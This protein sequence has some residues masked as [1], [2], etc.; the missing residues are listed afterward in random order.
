MGHMLVSD[1]RLFEYHVAGAKAAG[2]IP[3]DSEMS[4]ETVRRFIHDDQ[5]TVIVST[6]ENLVQEFGCFETAL[7]CLGNRYWTLVTAAAAALDF[8]TCDHPVT[9]RFTDPYRRGPCGYGLPETEVFFPLNTRQ[10]L[11]GVFEDP[12]PL[13][14]EVDTAQ[15]AAFN[16]R[17]INH[18]YRQVY[19]KTTNVAL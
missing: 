9:V 12:L 15:I 19:T 14:I 18:T 2:F 1:K 6:S 13:R 3:Q 7:Q 16:R 11:L 8:I 17:M 5:Y 10:A 4:F